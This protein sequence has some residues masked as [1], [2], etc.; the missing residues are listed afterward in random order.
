MDNRTLSERLTVRSGG[1]TTGEVMSAFGTTRAKTWQ[2][3]R[4]LELQGVLVGEARDKRGDYVERKDDGCP[5]TV[6][7]EILWFAP[8]PEGGVEGESPL[9]MAAA[10]KVIELLGVKS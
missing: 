6:G 1:L 5:A 4:S 2:A 7:G 8:C 3:L 10:T 9:S